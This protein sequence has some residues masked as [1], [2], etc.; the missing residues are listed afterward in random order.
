MTVLT[1]TLPDEGPGFLLDGGGQSP[2]GL[3][4]A[5]GVDVGPQ[6]DEVLLPAPCRQSKQLFHPVHHAAHRRA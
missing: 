5:Q 6:V 2:D 1:L 4:V 3:E